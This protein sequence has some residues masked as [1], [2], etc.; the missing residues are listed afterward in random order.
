M[1]SP[2]RGLQHFAVDAKKFAVSPIRILTGVSA[3]LSC[4]KAVLP[5]ASE[6]EESPA[7]LAG[8]EISD[9]VCVPLSGVFF[10]GV[11]FTLSAF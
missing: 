10:C 4:R 11:P 1:A 8:T 6:P 7:L 2:Q 5:A 9:T 3:V